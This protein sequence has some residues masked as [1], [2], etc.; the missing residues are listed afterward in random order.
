MK[1]PTAEQIPNRALSRRRFLHGASLTTLGALALPSLVAGSVLGRAGSTPPNSRILVACIGTGPQGRGVMGNF[2]SQPDCHVVALCDV[3]QDSLQRACN[4]VN[5]A[6]QNQD[7]Q[8]YTDF[9]E[10]LARQDIDAVL[11]ATPDHWHVPI[12]MAAAQAGK[13]VYLEKPMGLAVEEN[14]RLRRTLKEHGRLFQFGTQQRSSSQFWQACQLVRSGHIGTLKH[15]DVWC[16]ASQPGGSTQ[17]APVPPTINYDFWLGPAPHTPYTEQKCAEDGKTWWFTYDYALGFIAGWG[18]HPLDIAFWGCPSLAAGPLRVEGRG[19]IPTEGA[20]NTAVAWEVQF[21][22]HDGVTV[23]YR[24]TPNG[25]N[26]P[27]PLT[28]FNDWRQQYGRIVDHGTAFVGSEGWIVVDR[29]QIR[30]S[31]ESLVEIR[32]GSDDHLIKRSSHHVRDLLDCMRSRAQPV[33]NIDE[34][35]QADQLCHL[36]DL[37]IRLER[38]LTW[39]PRK[40]QFADDPDANRRLKIR[41]TR[42]PWAKMLA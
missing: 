1:A 36:S 9:R 4:Q 41:S 32:F 14:Q 19:I 8:A 39:D 22:A 15:I 20:C 33:C 24:G 30:T 18:V 27:S 7:A 16:A 12:T 5:Q 31:P 23:R 13:D 3:K 25:Y 40:E 11:V 2:L 28:D 26:T 42:E 21:R 37:A 29:T 17:P 34:A 6:Y 38:P 10:V 35:F